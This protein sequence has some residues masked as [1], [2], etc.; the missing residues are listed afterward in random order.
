MLKESTVNELILMGP[1]I[2]IIIA[3]TA[4]AVLTYL[5]G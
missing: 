2:V 4:V 3:L 5:E 1:S